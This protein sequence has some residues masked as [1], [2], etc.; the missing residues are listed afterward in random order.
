MER[1]EL[2]NKL[3]VNEHSAFSEADIDVLDGIRNGAE[4]IRAIAGEIQLFEQ[5][6]GVNIAFKDIRV[7]NVSVKYGEA[8]TVSNDS[9]V[10]VACDSLTV[11]GDPAP[12]SRLF[13][14]TRSGYSLSWV[15]VSQT[16]TNSSV[17]LETNNRTV[18]SITL[19]YQKESTNESHM[20]PFFTFTIVRQ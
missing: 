17:S 7:N 10:T 18:T 3:I 12:N 1:K 13:A 6:S 5:F 14:L 19:Y 16:G 8:V 9:S 2:I 20:Y 11:N 15:S 4:R